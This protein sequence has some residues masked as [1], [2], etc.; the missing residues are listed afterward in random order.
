GGDLSVER[1]LLAY[2]SGLFPW[3]SAGD[4]L[5]WWCPDP[6]FVLFPDHFKLR[7]SLRK[8]IAAGR[9]QV[10]R[11]RAFEQVVDHCSRQ[12]RTGQDGTW[13]LPEM[14]DAY[15]RLH[16]AGYA[17]SVEAWWEGH[18]VGG[19]YGVAMGPFF[20]GESMFHLETDASKVALAA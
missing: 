7:R 20:F 12:P 11:D 13:I 5:L 16:R 8:T 4:P 9:F 17:H 19:L 2:R 15:C 18:L 1:L 10:H 14:R 6:R 3:Y